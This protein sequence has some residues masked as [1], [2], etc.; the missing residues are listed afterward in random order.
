MQAENAD[1]AGLTRFPIR[2][3][4]FARLLTL[5]PIIRFFASTYARACANAAVDRI[6]GSKVD[7]LIPVARRFCPL[8][9][10][11]SSLHAKVTLTV[12]RLGRDC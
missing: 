6:A 9:R 4:T 11:H 7:G 10:V 3:A 1:S 5:A 2:P 8:L 12:P